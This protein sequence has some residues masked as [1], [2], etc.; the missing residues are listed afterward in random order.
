VEREGKM[1]VSSG[2]IT[3]SRHTA[4]TATTTSITLTDWSFT[5]SFTKAD[6]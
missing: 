2:F 1:A 6:K 5:T 3:N 4:I